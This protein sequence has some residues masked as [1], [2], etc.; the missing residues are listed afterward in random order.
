MHKI[1]LKEHVKAQNAVQVVKNAL[2]QEGLKYQFWD[3]NS[4]AFLKIIGTKYTYDVMIFCA[5]EFIT[6]QVRY[7]FLVPQD[8]IN[9][10]FGLMNGINIKNPVGNLELLKDNT[11]LAVKVGV[12]IK[13]FEPDIKLVIE[14]LTRA[15]QFTNSIVDDI[16][17]AIFYPQ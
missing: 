15:F 16:E 11:T 6:I 8:R 1:E 14:A 3:E 9:S 7:P 12:S 13:S 4:V 2:D 17:Q 10:V 5:D